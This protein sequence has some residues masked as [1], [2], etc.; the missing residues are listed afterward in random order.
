[1]LDVRVYDRAGTFLDVVPDAIDP[2]FQEQLNVPGSFAFGLQVDSKTWART[3]SLLDYGNIVKLDDGNHV[4]AGRIEGKQR[5]FVA[6]RSAQ[7]CQVSGRGMLAVLEDA[8]VYPE[9][10]LVR[11]RGDSRPFNF[12]SKEGAWRVT[13]EWSEP[14]FGPWGSADVGWR[15]G[16]PA[17]WPDPQGEWMWPSPGPTDLNAQESDAYFRRDFTTATSGY[18][19]FYCTGDNEFELWVNGSLVLSGDSWATSYS[20]DVWVPAGDTLVAI[21]GH[22]WPQLPSTTSTAGVLF[23]MYTIGGDGTTGSILRR[24]TSGAGWLARMDNGDP[25]G[26]SPGLVLSTL[27]GEAQ[28]T[29][30]GGGVAALAPLS[31]SWTDTAD[32]DGVAWTTAT[33][34]VVD[35]TF[36]IAA[37]LLSV[38]TQL[39]ETSADIRIEGSTLAVEMRLHQGADKTVDP[40]AVVLYPAGSLVD[41]DYQGDASAQRSVLLVQ[42]ADGQWYERGITPSPPRREAG[43]QVGNATSQRQIDLVVDQTLAEHG[44]PTEQF[45]VQVTGGSPVPFV[46]FTVGDTVLIPDPDDGELVAQRVVAIS[47]K[48]QDRQVLYTPELSAVLKSREQRQA[49]TLTSMLGGTLGGRVA[50]AGPVA[51]QTRVA[52]AVA[53]AASG[54]KILTPAADVFPISD[55]S[56]TSYTLSQ[57]PTAV[58]A[59]VLNGLQQRATDVVVN[60]SAGTVDVTALRRKAGDVLQ[61]DYEH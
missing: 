33:P 35:R 31:V 19:R 52:A 29:A 27:I 2:Q 37:D 32:T 9:Y 41:A 46:D 30:R 11:F 40:G 1:M 20:V 23:A 5:K 36:P 57:T 13:A 14:M 55:A 61:V 45:T 12:A 8:I 22:N 4:F 54:G 15:K 47:V 10:G 49:Q 28:A 58:T 3:P 60:L 51:V 39:A 38:A 24:S 42:G 18:Y 21:K 16:S 26:W 6:E 56:V 43:L 59:V 50:N 7:V 44:S 17:D 48:Q 34:A 53:G 25:P